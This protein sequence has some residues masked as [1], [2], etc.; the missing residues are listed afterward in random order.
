[1]ND[2]QEDDP[3]SYSIF[4]SYFNPTGPKKPTK[5]FIPF[6]LWGD[7][8]EAAK[9][10]TIDYNKKIKVPNQRPY[11]NGGNNKP[12]PTLGKSNPKPQQVHFHG[13]DPPPDN[14]PTE[15]STQTLVMNVYL[16]VEWTHLILTMSCQLSRPRLENLNTHQRYVFAR[17]NQCT[18]HLDDKG[19][20]GGLAGADIRILKKD[21][22]INIV[23]IDHHELT[24]LDFHTQKGPLI[25]IF[26]EYTHL[27]KGRSIHPAQQ[28]EWFNY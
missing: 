7:F 14:S 24:G 3:S 27:G 20:N 8:L 13:N 15:T 10:M 16:M 21:R 22:K 11:S 1:M 2:S 12:K 6:Q 9:Q 23:G 25:A 18:N 19:G 28:M 4:Q 17:A 26:H 5:V